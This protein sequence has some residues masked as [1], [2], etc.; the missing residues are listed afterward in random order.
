[1]IQK[2]FDLTPFFRGAVGLDRF[3]DRFENATA[4]NTSMSYPPYNVL[5]TGENAYRV[6]L[7]VAGFRNDELDVQVEDGTLTI[8][9]R[10]EVTET[11]ETEEYQYRGISSKD[12]RRTFSLADGI[13][14]RSAKLAD[15][16]L[17]VELE[18]E[19]PE[20]KKARSITIKN[21]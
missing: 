6:E 7:A 17:T 15:G 8:S 3:F 13:E 9:G 14:V 4:F 2:Q 1:M 20:A 5:K 11:S 18:R 16:L 12:F 10:K 19:I 21:S